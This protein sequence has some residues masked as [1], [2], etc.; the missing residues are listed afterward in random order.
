MP[1][2]LFTEMN[3]KRVDTVWVDLK[4]LPVPIAFNRATYDFTVSDSSVACRLILA[5]SVLGQ[6]NWNTS[7]VFKSAVDF[8]FTSIKCSSGDFITPT[9]SGY[10]LYATTGSQERSVVFEWQSRVLAENG[11]RSTRFP[12]PMVSKGEISVTVPSDFSDVTVDDAVIM[13]QKNGVQKVMRFSLAK[14]DEGE[15]SFVVPPS[16]LRESDGDSIEVPIRGTQIFTDQQTAVLI[17]NGHVTGLTNLDIE[18]LNVPVSI[19]KIGIPENNSLLRVDGKGISKWWQADDSLIVVLGFDLLGSYSLG[20]IAE[21]DTQSYISVPVY[22]IYSSERTTGMFAVALGG[23]G[24]PMMLQQEKSQYLPV[25]VFK[26]KVSKRLAGMIS[27]YDVKNDDYLFAGSIQD[28]LSQVV[29][30]LVRYNVFP[31]VSAIADSSAVVTLISDDGKMVTEVTCWVQQRGKQ[32]VSF[33][34]PDTCDVWRV[35]VDNT[36]RTPFIDDKGKLRISLQQRNGITQDVQKITIVYYNKMNRMRT[37]NLLMQCPVPDLPVSSLTWIIYYPDEWHLKSTRS[38]IAFSKGTVFKKRM[39]LPKGESAKRYA[40]F[41]NVAS[42]SDRLQKSVSM[43]KSPN[44]IT[45][46][47]ILVVNENP[48]VEMQ[49]SSKSSLFLLRTI[50][51]CVVLGLVLL[52]CFRLVMKTRRGEVK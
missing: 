18:V 25:P 15:L 52:F 2:D 13:S 6:E 42:V 10:A 44:H 30:S 40:E 4:V 12:I 29:F 24:E 9:D 33:K 1:F 38:D 39:Q 43:P 31:V 28:S 46:N 37:G 14:S 19:L 8:C 34:L 16:A 41:Q 47:K 5:Y 36:S 21:T 11:R 50:L 51:L 17:K 27:E 35:E 45:G 3:Q 48:F 20:L 7:N 49:F 32:F 26:S 23:S 22:K